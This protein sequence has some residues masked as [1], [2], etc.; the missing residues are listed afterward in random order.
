V[1]ILLVFG[2]II[3]LA[4]ATTYGLYAVPH[5][6]AKTDRRITNGIEKFAGR[7]A[8]YEQWEMAADLYQR[9]LAEEPE[10]VSILRK[11]ARAYRKMGDEARFREHIDQALALDLDAYRRRPSRVSVNLS[12]V[13]S[14][15]E[16]GQWG[17]AEAHLQQALHAGL[18]RVERKPTSASAAYWLGKTYVLLE[19]QASALA[20]FERAFALK[21][22]SK[23]YRKALLKARSRAE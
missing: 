20:Q 5:L 17:N 7:Y 14:Y 2:A 22:T 9:L 21:P 13:R 16:L 10:E 12:L 18:Q 15:R 3:A 6:A 19:D 1:I 8:R 23:K 11:L 4:T